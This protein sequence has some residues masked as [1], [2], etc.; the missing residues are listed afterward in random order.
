[1]TLGDT[2]CRVVVARWVAFGLHG[3]LKR[4]FGSGTVECD[5]VYVGEITWRVGRTWLRSSTSPAPGRGLGIGR[6]HASRAGLP[7]A[8]YGHDPPT[9]R[10]KA[11]SSTPTV[12]MWGRLL[13]GLTRTAMDLQPWPAAVDP[14]SRRADRPARDLAGNRRSGRRY[15][16]HRAP[17]R[18]AGS[19]NLEWTRLSE[20]CRAVDAARP[21]ERLRA[22]RLAP[23]SAANAAERTRRARLGTHGRWGR[24]RGHRSPRPHPSGWESLP[25]AVGV[26]FWI[27]FTAVAPNRPQRGLRT[28]AIEPPSNP[29]RL[30]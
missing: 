19:A 11:R 8:A 6:P 22:I 29:G 25:R 30:M 18:H 17:H 9:A 13:G 3:G 14:R 7:R 12:S 1:V 2:S 20:R 21:V 10:H 26:L 24:D 16:R 28:Q 15:E 27:V 4:A 5:R 23:F